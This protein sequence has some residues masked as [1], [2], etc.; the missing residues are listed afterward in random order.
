MYKNFGEYALY[1]HNQNGSL[2]TNE[3][4]FLPWMRKGV[5]VALL[6]SETMHRD[7]TVTRFEERQITV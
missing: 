1:T 5:T 3:T 4:V 2:T 7:Q 6:F